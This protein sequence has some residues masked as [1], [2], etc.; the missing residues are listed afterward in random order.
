MPAVLQHLTRY[1]AIRQPAA[2]LA[3]PRPCVQDALCHQHQN[4][5][6][7]FWRVQGQKSHPCQ[8]GLHR[9][10]HRLT[11]GALQRCGLVSHAPSAHAYPRLALCATNSVLAGCQSKWKQVAWPAQAVRGQA[12]L[13]ACS[14]NLSI[15]WPLHRT[16]PPSKSTS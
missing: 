3:V 16:F 11:H 14:D 8:R 10:M 2:D 5:H 6:A 4:T 12:G 7:V 9:L 1:A 13:R 15:Q